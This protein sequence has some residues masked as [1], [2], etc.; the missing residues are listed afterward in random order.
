MSHML[1]SL[2]VRLRGK[3]YFLRTE[4]ENYLLLV[5]F[6]NEDI[7]VKTHLKALQVVTLSLFL[8]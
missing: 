7:L 3:N 1:L 2:Q 6:Y 5:G 4:T 8:F